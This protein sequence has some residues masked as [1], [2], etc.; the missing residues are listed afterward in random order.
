MSK[1]RS[2]LGRRADRTGSV[3]VFIRPERSVL[4]RLLAVLWQLRTELSALVVGVWCWL[5][6]TD[7]MPIW[8]ALTV[9]LVAAGS[10]TAWSPSRRF[11]VGHVWC[12]VTRHRLRSC[13]VQSRIMN[14]RG[15]VPWCLWVRPTNVGERVWLL[16]RP[17]IC[18]EDLE[19]KTPQIA[20]ACWARDARVRAMRRLV[21]VVAVDVIRRDPLTTGR[22]IGSPLPA[23]AGGLPAALAGLPVDLGEDHPESRLREDAEEWELGADASSAVLREAVRRRHLRAVH[24]TETARPAAKT[25]AMPAESAKPAR[26]VARPSGPGAVSSSG[27]DV[28][29]YV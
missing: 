11:V 26:P 19:A 9:A 29:D 21:A 23:M 5:W 1:S 15:Y 12:T 18:V 2:P 28:S 22:L 8:A 17:G 13:L 4:V 27:E 6:L 10:V 14:Y 25:S 16:M 20:A 24:E 7:R 3:E